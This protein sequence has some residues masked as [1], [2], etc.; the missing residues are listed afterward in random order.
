MKIIVQV[1]TE[2]LLLSITITQTEIEER[3]RLEDRLLTSIGLRQEV[4][5]RTSRNHKSK[6]IKINFI[7]AS[8][9]EYSKV[10]TCFISHRRYR[11]GGSSCCFI[12]FSRE[13][14]SSHM[15]L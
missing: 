10:P 6:G 1:T 12:M 7:K 8:Y 15:N 11:D 3:S 9:Q 14:L 4:K 2:F 5:H 13:R